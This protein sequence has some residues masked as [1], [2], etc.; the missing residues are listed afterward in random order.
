MLAIGLAHNSFL[1]ELSLARNAVHVAGV[2][3]LTAALCKNTTLRRCAL[4]NRKQD[5][6]GCC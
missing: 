1:R 6:K 2:K 3:K 4:Q 5:G